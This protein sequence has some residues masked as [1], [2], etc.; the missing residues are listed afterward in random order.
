MREDGRVQRRVDAPRVARRGAHALIDVVVGQAEEGR[1]HRHPRREAEHEAELGRHGEQLRAQRGERVGHARVDVHRVREEAVEDG[2]GA[3]AV[4]EGHRRV[5]QPAQQLRVQHARGPQRAQRE[6][7]RLHRGGDLGPAA[8]EEVDPEGAAL[9]RA[10][11]FGGC[12]R[13]VGPMGEEEVGGHR[14]GGGG[15]RCQE[16]RAAAADRAK[17]AQVDGEVRSGDQ[18][19][20][21]RLLL[22]AARRVGLLATQLGQRGIDPPR[23]DAPALQLAER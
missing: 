2:A 18:P 21:P 3:H 1:G 4:E 13:R 16:Q 20:A 22:A 17:L 11:L 12:R 6:E 15:H 23:R 9:R 19:V 10:R 8:E 5:Q 7:Q 14:G